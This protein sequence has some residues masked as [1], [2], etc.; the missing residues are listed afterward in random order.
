MTVS[1]GRYKKGSSKIGIS[2]SC[3]KFSHTLNVSNE[4]VNDD[5]HCIKIPKR[6]TN[7]DLLSK[8]K[9]LEEYGDV[10]DTLECLPGE[11]HLE[12]H[13]S[14]QPSTAHGMEDTSCNEGGNNEENCQIN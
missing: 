7:G 14:I 3:T 2:K 10:F 11:L 13:K 1:T 4:Q 12:V 5:I 6:K 8:K 9:I